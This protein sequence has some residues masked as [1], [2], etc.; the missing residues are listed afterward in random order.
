[1]REEILFVRGTTLVRRQVMEPGETLPW[2]V[3]PHHRVSVVLRGSRLQIEFR[4]T[5]ERKEVL[6]HPGQVGWD[7][8]TNRVHRALNVGEPYEEVTV[9]FRD[10]ED[11]PHQP[12]S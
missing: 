10:R 6:V 12:P 11:A 9:F 3:D 2:H 5:L 4:D 7:E 1:V 8:P